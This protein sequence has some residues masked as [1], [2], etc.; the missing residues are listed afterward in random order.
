MVMNSCNTNPAQNVCYPIINPAYTGNGKVLNAPAITS[1]TLG[2]TVYL[3]PNA[4]TKPPDYQFSTIARTAPY[5]SLFQPGNYKLDLSLRRS[6][7]IPTGGLHE[8]ARFVMEADYFNVT[9]HT[10]FVYSQASAPLNTWGT[11]SY[12]TLVVDS[13][14][15]TQRALQLAAR[16]EF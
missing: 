16:I 12:G 9:N 7:K 10:H 8:S 2:K 1:D 13:N 14:S 3:D 4:F 6:F 11:S 5:A 15:A